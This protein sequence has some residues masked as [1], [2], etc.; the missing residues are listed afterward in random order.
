M[1]I[2]L[3]VISCSDF[4]P[5]A[6]SI[7][8]L[9]KIH[10]QFEGDSSGLDISDFRTEPDLQI[11]SIKPTDT[12]LELSLDRKTPVQPDQHYYLHYK[13]KAAI[14]ARPQG[15]LDLFYSDKT[16]GHSK[17]GEQNIFRL[18]APR[19]SQVTLVSYPTHDAT[20]GKEHLMK[21]DV[22]G[23]WEISLPGDLSGTYYG[24]RVK[25]PS[26][27]GEIFD[28]SLVLA[29]PYSRAVSTRNEYQHPGRTLILPPSDFDWGN[30]K[31]V[32]IE[33]PR[34]L[35]IYEMHVRDLTMHPSAKTPEALKGSYT[36]LVTEQ[37]TGGIAHLKRLGV[38]AVEL[39][40]IHDFGNIEVPFKDRDAPV[41][42]TWNPYVRNHWGYMTSYFFAPESYYAQGG[43][44]EP[45]KYN[46]IDGRQVDEFKQLV[47]TFHDNDIAVILDVVYNH[48]SQYDLN[49]FKFIDKH[50]YFR[51]ND[52]LSFASVS[53][54][55]NDFKTERKMARRMIIESVKFWMTEYHIDGFRFDLAK[56]IDWE[57]C[58]EVLLEA[59]KINPDVIIIA[60][61]WGGGYDPAGFSDRGWPSWNDQFRN[62]IKGQNPYDGLGFIFGEWQGENDRKSLERYVTGSLREDKG[63]YVDVRHSVNYLES[64]DDHT[65]GDFIR[66]GLKIVADHDVIEDIDEHAKLSAAELKLNKLAAISLFT[67]QGITMIHSGQEWARS[68]IIAA[69]TVGDSAVGRIDHNSYEKDNETNWLNFDHE[70]LNSELVDYYRG[71]IRLRRQHPGLRRADKSQ[72]EIAD[73]ND[74]HFIS[75]QISYPGEELLVALNGN[76]TETHKLVL[77]DGNWQLLA[78]DKQSDFKQTVKGKQLMVP[79]TSGLLLRK[80]GKGD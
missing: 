4:T 40:P 55:G 47:K 57:T 53:G 21:K 49:P 5:T 50:Y 80:A 51:L 16:L 11:M 45:G 46:G 36:G 3:A 22:D 61:P 65:L 62:G 17:D 68:K 71:L 38:N 54:C 15:L 2:G 66:L 75:W 58:E 64:H 31:W 18:F 78:N 33:D 56:L 12:H 26:G 76:P 35:V 39:L 10:I 77:P 25:G 6:A 19:A 7:E 37:Q 14:F 79:P 24:Y 27:P 42:N 72:I 67:S 30:D 13:D 34:D 20:T 52:D 70:K 63:Q 8:S 48:V 44:M 73:S 41:Y 59:R 28:E 23:V 74:P 69:N 60:E 32:K 43:N 9:H 1:L 29:D